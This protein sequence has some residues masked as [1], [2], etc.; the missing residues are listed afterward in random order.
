MA[1]SG[2]AASLSRKR[3]L[4]N[5]QGRKANQRP[6][7]TPEEEAEIAARD[8]AAERILSKPVKSKGKR[9]KLKRPKGKSTTHVVILAIIGIS[10]IAAIIGLR[11]LAEAFG[12]RWI[13]D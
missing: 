1:S 13:G 3:I 7:P 4:A 8:E 12:V 10:G 11:Y 6:E 5:V 9:T 2:S